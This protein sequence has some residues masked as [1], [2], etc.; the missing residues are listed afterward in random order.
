MGPSQCGD[1]EESGRHSPDA[2]R[3]CYTIVGHDPVPVQ[4]PLSRD[5]SIG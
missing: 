2:F 5:L 4:I 3:T 1:V